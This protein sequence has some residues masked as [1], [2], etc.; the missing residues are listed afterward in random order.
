MGAEKGSLE[1][2]FYQGLLLQALTPLDG[3]DITQDN[4]DWGDLRAVVDFFS[5]GHPFGG[6][7]ERSKVLTQTR[8]TP[9]KYADKN[10]KEQCRQ[11]TESHSSGQPE[12]GGSENLL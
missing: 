2:H 3:S 11:R 7:R 6:V 9:D 12:T 8:R 5:T 1:L 10:R 4:V